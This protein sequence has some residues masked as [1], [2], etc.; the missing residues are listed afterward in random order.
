MKFLPLGLM[1]LL[2]LAGCAQPDSASDLMGSSD[3]FVTTL[4][5]VLDSSTPGVMKM[6]LGVSYPGTRDYPGTAQVL[7][8]PPWNIASSR[9]WTQRTDLFSASRWTDEDEFWYNFWLLDV[10]SIHRQKLRDPRTRANHDLNALYADLGS[11]VFTAYV[12]PADT[13]AFIDAISGVSSDSVF[14]IVYSPFHADTL[15]VGDLAPDGVAKASGIRRKDRILAVD[16]VTG[17]SDSLMAYMRTLSRSARIRFKVRHLGGDTATVEMVRRPAY[18]NPVWFDTLPGGNAYL[19]ISQFVQDTTGPQVQRAVEAL[20]GVL[21]NSG[22]L[23]VDLRDNLGGEVG[24]ALQTASVLLPKGDTLIHIRSRDIDIMSNQ[25]VVTDTFHVNR[26]GTLLAHPRIL[27]LTNAYTASS[28]EMVLSALRENLPTADIKQFGTRT[29]GKGIG[30][31]YQSTPNGG[32]SRITCL[33]IAPLHSSSYNA[34]GIQPTL[35]VPD[36]LVDARVL[37]ELYPTAARAA[38]GQGMGTALRLHQLSMP[39]YPGPLGYIRKAR[40]NAP[41]VLSKPGN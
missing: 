4:G 8:V 9:S 14:G 36:S 1:A 25:G 6:V 40:P 5:P 39:R 41:G 12:S 35:E 15:V 19:S 7:A 2:G 20:A 31:I 16:S 3:A 28:A 11:D 34:I 17:P 38:S 37:T 32:I 24:T 22:W 29:Y 18:F 23:I 10:F 27:A 30:Q 33:E 21:G 26:I 13:Q